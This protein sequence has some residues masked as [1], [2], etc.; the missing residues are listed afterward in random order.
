MKRERNEQQE[1]SCTN[2]REENGA[3]VLEGLPIV[4]GVRSENL[5]PY[6]DEHEV[7]EVLKVGCID[8]SLIG[9]SD[10]VLNI[11]HSNDVPNV[12]GRSRG[13]DGTLKLSV[14]E[15]GVYCE[16][17]LPETA[18]AEAVAELVRRGD[19]GG[20]SFA[21]DDGGN[22][23]YKRE[24]DKDGKEVWIREVTKIVGL[25]D[26][27]VVTHPAYSDTSVGLRS[28]GD[29]ILR[30]IEAIK[31]SEDKQEVEATPED[32]EMEEAA[33]RAAEERGMMRYRA[34]RRAGM[35]EI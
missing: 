12:L 6:S 22:V 33:R 16:C 5:T 26:V 21:F 10:V 8:D 32:K 3:Q 19:I 20:M 2:V 25:Y 13:G 17:P 14:S 1:Y 27:S 24:S 9:M 29:A 4:F 34:R 11:N 7:Y 31:P 35:I 30:E 18:N 15:L 23:I 28:R